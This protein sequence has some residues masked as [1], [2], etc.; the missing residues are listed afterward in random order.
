M[1]RPDLQ[2]AHEEKYGKKQWDSGR[3]TIRTV[4]NGTVP[5]F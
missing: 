3:L 2:V 5:F 1:Y 4:L